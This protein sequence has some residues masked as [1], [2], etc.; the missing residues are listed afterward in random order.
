MRPQSL[1]QTLHSLCNKVYL[2]QLILLS[3]PLTRWGHKLCEL[4]LTECPSRRTP[5]TGV[6]TKSIFLHLYYFFVC[7]FLLFIN[8]PL[9][10]LWLLVSGGLKL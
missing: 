2:V 6:S 7:A 9:E 10:T 8:G 4:V 5:L 3:V 1:P